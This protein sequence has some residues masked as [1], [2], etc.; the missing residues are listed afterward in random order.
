MMTRISNISISFQYWYRGRFLS[1]TAHNTVYC[2]ITGIVTF[3]LKVHELLAL[4]S[5]SLTCPVVSNVTATT[6]TYFIEHGIAWLAHLISNGEHCAGI[7]VEEKR[8]L[9]CRREWNLWGN[10]FPFEDRFIKAG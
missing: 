1:D 5:G 4:L 7:W 2:L 8:V 9:C 10:G 6:H 3:N